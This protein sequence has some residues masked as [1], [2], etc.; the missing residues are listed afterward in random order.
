MVSEAF[1]CQWTLF[2]NKWKL[3]QKLQIS[4]PL[5][6]SLKWSGKIQ[7][8]HCHQVGNMHLWSIFTS[9]LWFC[10]ELK[11]SF[12]VWNVIISSLNTFLSNFPHLLLILWKGIKHILSPRFLCVWSC[13]WAPGERNRILLSWTM[14]HF[15]VNWTI[16]FFFLLSKKKKYHSVHSH[17]TF[18][19]KNRYQ[20][21]TGLLHLEWLFHWPI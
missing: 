10:C 9:S 18:F 7:A 3:G 17:F 14:C 20:H 11:N 12:S 8:L 2:L 16:Q 1:L 5:W 13:G 6:Q 4:I 21:Q 15:N 19:L